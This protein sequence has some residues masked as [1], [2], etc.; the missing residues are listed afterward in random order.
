MSRFIGE[1]DLRVLIG[2]KLWKLLKDFGYQSDRYAMTIT[3]D[4]DF[5]C[6]FASIP[7]LFWRLIGPPATG[8]YR[9]AAIIHDWLYRLYGSTGVTRKKA[10]GI[11]YE[12]M[13]CDGTG[14]IRAWIIYRAVR[15]GGWR[16]WN[17]YLTNS[18]LQRM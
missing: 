3:A 11:F 8:K 5:K 9:R 4:K 17:R 16:P 10:D 2:G 1:L 7:R 12:A 13:I 6:D 18:A 15:A 14:H